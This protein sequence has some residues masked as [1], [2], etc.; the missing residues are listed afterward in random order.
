MYAAEYLD[1]YNYA[2][3]FQIM[4]IARNVNSVS[5]ITSD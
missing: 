1:T 5:E 4:D 2:N 3:L